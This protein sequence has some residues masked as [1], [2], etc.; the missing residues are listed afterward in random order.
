MPMCSLLHFHDHP[1]DYLTVTHV[2]SCQLTFHWCLVCVCV[3]VAVHQLWSPVPATVFLI[4]RRL[5]LRYIFKFSLH[6]CHIWYATLYTVDTQKAFAKLKGVC[7]CVCIKSLQSCLTLWDSV[8]CSP[9]DSSAHGILQ[10]R[11]LEWVAKCPSWYGNI[12]RCVLSL[13][14]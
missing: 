1:W 5:V 8:D 9:P 4:I 7:V 14:I 11:I 10:A 2:W 3:C 6:L 13:V 12:Q